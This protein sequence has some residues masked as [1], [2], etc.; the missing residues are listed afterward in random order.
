MLPAVIVCQFS[1]LLAQQPPV[2]TPGSRVRVTSADSTVGA[3]TGTVLGITETT[4]RLRRGPSEIPIALPAIQRLELS[5]GHRPSVAGGIVGLALGVAA[6]GALGCLANSD[7]YGVFCAG[8]KDTKV[9]GGAVIGGAVGAV[10]LSWLLRSERWS[11]VPHGQL[12]RSP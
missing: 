5:G 11:V 1:G 8:Q 7:S 12:R 9:V 4:L 10:L 3:Q 6:G 2:L